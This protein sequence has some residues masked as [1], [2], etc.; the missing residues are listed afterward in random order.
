MNNSHPINVLWVEDNTEYKNSFIPSA[1]QLARELQADKDYLFDLDFTHFTNWEQAKNYLASNLDEVQVV[2]LDAHCKTYESYASEDNEFLHYSVMDMLLIF[3]KFH[4]TRPWYILSAGTMNRFSETTTVI[5]HYRQDFEEEWGRMIYTKRG[6]QN[7]DDDADNGD[8]FAKAN[9]SKDPDERDLIKSILKAVDQPKAALFRHRDTLRYLGRDKLFK[10]SSRATLLTLLDALYNPHLYAGYR[11]QGNPIRKIFESIVH[12][13][14]EKGIIP[15]T[16]RPH[17]KVLCSEASR[18]L[19]GKNPVS[20][21]HRF[22]MENDKILNSNEESILIAVLTSANVASHESKSDLEETD[23]IITDNN[24]DEF[25]GCALLMCRIIKALGKYITENQ[26]IATNKSKWR[27]NP[28]L[29]EGK[30]YEIKRCGEILYAGQCLL[31]SLQWLHEGNKIE[32]R[33]I[34]LNNRETSDEFPF[35]C[36]KPQTPKQKK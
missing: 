17:G 22:G 30:H 20:L 5:S 19:S 3:A 12:T 29:L 9:F 18:F 11:F 6:L 23:V 27:L 4:T 2:V 16:I 15:D 13:C 28:G 10:G 8:I 31:P 35:Y 34:V 14:A 26:D 7:F 21:E 25:A 24:R 36:N 1:K 32:L 33:E